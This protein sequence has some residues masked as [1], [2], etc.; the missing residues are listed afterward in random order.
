IDN[1]GWRS[2]F[3][4]NLP[5]GIIGLIMAWYFIEESVSEKKSV[6]FD[7][8]GAI[9]LGLALSALVL[10]LDRGLDWGWLSTKSIITY[11]AI[12]AFT[13]IFIIVERRQSE[14]IVD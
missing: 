3:L 7:W 12:I 6:V 5:V 1:F 10:V 13:V 8:W 14:P 11:G 2:V 9:T 4:I